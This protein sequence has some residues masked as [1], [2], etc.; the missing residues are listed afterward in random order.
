MAILKDQETGAPTRKVQVSSLTALPTAIIGAPVILWIWGMIA[1]GQ[2][3]PLE[4]AAAIGGF[5]T[6]AVQSIT[7]YMTKNR[8]GEGS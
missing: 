6:W 8:A 4:V 3:M 2:E 1:P 5:V 7:A